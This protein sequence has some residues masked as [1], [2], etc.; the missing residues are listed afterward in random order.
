MNA[1]TLLHHFLRLSLLLCLFVFQLIRRQLWHKF[2]LYFWFSIFKFFSPL[3]A[4][5]KDAE[6]NKSTLADRIE[7]ARTE[8]AA[9]QTRRSASLPRLDA[10]TRGLFYFLTAQ[11]SQNS[12]RTRT[13]PQRSGLSKAHGAVSARQWWKPVSILRAKRHY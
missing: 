13:K 4:S 1:L 9:G 5:I 10:S 3:S 8:A 12:L 11:I 7:E 2:V 6:I